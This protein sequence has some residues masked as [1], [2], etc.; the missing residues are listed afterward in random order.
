M[1]TAATTQKKEEAGSAKEVPAT[2]GTLPSTLARWERDL[3]SV[4]EDLFEDFGRTRPWAR[5]L[6]PKRLRALMKPI[7]SID[8]LEQGDEIVVRAELP[9]MQ[10]EDIDVRLTDSTLTVKGEKK[11]E[12]EVKEEDY[13]RSERTFGSI[14][15]TVSLPA[16]V[17]ADAAKATFKD[18][19]LEVRLP[20][21]EEAKQK[22][23]KVQVQ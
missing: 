6:E 17:K 20:K 14:L 2:R 13:H 9:G 12:E 4:F 16:E 22:P 1:A 8:V 15:R 23:V 10:K 7:P 11:R 19:V 21:T 3:E 5:L 18:G